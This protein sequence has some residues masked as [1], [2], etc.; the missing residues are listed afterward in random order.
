MLPPGIKATL[1]S[2]N[3]GDAATT[4]DTLLQS[5]SWNV[6]SWNVPNKDNYTSLT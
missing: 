1:V 3:I 4:L 2:L 6:T 5:L